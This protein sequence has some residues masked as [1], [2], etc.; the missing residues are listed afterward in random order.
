MNENTPLLDVDSVHPADHATSQNFLD[1]PFF[2]GDNGDS[3][4]AGLEAR[5]GETSDELAPSPTRKCV[6]GDEGTGHPSFAI[7][8]TGVWFYP[9]EGDPIWLCSP[10]MVLAETRDKNQSSWGRLL[11]WKDG[12]GHEHRWSCPAEL[13]QASDQS[14]FRRILASGGLIISTNPKA[15]RLLADYVLTYQS[16][17]KARC[18]DRTG[19]HGNSYVLDA[20]RV[21]GEDSN[22]M[23]VYQGAATSDFSSRGDL[24]GWRRNVAALAVG[25]S[26]IIAA[27][28]TAFAG[29]LTEFAGEVGGGIQF[30]GTTS[31]GK[32]STLMDPAA[33]VWGHPDSFAKKWRSTTNGLEALCLDRNH[34]VLILDDLGQ[35][36]AREAGQAAYMIANGQGKARMTKEAYARPLTTWKTLLLSSGEIDLNSHIE[37]TGKK[38]K[39]GQ[40]VRLPSIPCDA[41]S[42]WHTVEDLHGCPDGAEFSRKIK[43]ETR[44]HYGTAGIEF[45]RAVTTHFDEA[46]SALKDA[47]AAIVKVLL[48][49]DSYSPEMIRVAERFALISYSGEFA[50]RHGITG[51]EVG[52]VQA[53]VKRC[54]DDW[55]SQH[56][57]HS[58]A[59]HDE[60]ALLD[61]VSEYLQMFGGS[62]FPARD[63]DDT[64]LARVHDRSGFSDYCEGGVQYLV[65]SQAF[66]NKLCQGFD[67][68]DAIKT[69]IKKRWLIQ[70]PERDQTKLR[71]QALGGKRVWVYVMSGAAIEGGE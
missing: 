17:K 56:P 20:S 36:D 57:G 19:W 39:G 42:G 53:A 71:I 8:D 25:N 47:M 10:L 6:P 54:F 13:L 11:S 33:S 49:N 62:R 12:D 14:E 58:G 65:E 21:V 24:D 52:A 46:V 2:T 1:R 69:L 30:T 34:N 31:K 64:E 5:S 9:Y 41:G 18:V 60:Q 4:D 67:Y 40:A 48:P 59:G 68:R 7:N 70:G 22:E 29:V 55:L 61:Q 45:L 38:A 43:A 50:T 16:G 27:I 15:R 28:S 32:T 23:V 51:W 37:T 44:E 66:K 26:R 63:A 35:I 3:G